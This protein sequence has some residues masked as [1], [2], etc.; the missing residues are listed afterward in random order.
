MR[1][2]DRACD[3][4]ADALTLERARGVQPAEVRFSSGGGRFFARSVGAGKSG[5]IGAAA[6]L[7]RAG[8]SLP[9]ES[10]RRRDLDMPRDTARRAR[11]RILAN[12]AAM[13][14]PATAPAKR[15]KLVGHKNFKRN[16]PMSDKFAVHRFH[17]VEFWCG[18]AT[19]TSSRFAVG[20]GIV[21]VAKSD[22]STGNKT[23]ASYALKSND[24]M[25]VFSA[26]SYVPED[27]ARTSEARAA[28]QRTLASMPTPCVPSA[29]NTQHGRARRGCRRRRRRGCVREERLE[30]GRGVMPPARLFDD[31]VDETSGCPASARRRGGSL[32]GRRP[33]IR[34]PTRRPR[35]NVPAEVPGGTPRARRRAPV[36]R[37]DAVRP[38]GGERTRSPRDGGLHLILHRLPRVCRVHRRGRRHRRQWAQLHGAREQQRVRS[39]AR[40]RAHVRD[41]AWRVRFR[42]TWSRTKGQVCSTSR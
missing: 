1:C 30:R 39:P 40:E 20:L 27:E 41:E 29:R 10:E 38:R 18:D 31:G 14:D 6:N 4:G 37:L 13:S 26:A 9:V 2:V 21:R 17:H 12:T 7:S 16:N 3:T 11:A 36:L 28:S 32:R 15:H 42:R 25:F 5:Q 24:L 19:T 8:V 34:Q 33:S 35:G 22:L 23:Y